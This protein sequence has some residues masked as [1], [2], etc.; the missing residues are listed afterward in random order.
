MPDLNNDYMHFVRVVVTSEDDAT[1]Y[2]NF[3]LPKDPTIMLINQTTKSMTV[4]QEGS[5]TLLCV[6][7][8]SSRAYAYDMQNSKT[9]KLELTIG[10]D[11]R[12][13]NFDKLEENMVPLG[14]Y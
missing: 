11:S 4:Q 3:L 9:K 8:K 13:Y 7:A 14:P 1:I 5:P 6:I 10:G 2:V 12:S